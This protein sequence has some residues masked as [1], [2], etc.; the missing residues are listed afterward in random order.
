[1]KK[2]ERLEVTTETAETTS[3]LLVIENEK[4]IKSN[5]L[6]TRELHAA[7]RNLD[8]VTEA[9]RVIEEHEV[10]AREEIITLGEK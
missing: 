2:A 9:R 6:L 7:V 4:L 3:Q 10:S 5:R 8:E 1:M